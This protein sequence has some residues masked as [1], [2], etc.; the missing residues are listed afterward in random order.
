MNLVKHTFTLLALAMTVAASGSEPRPERILSGY[1]GYFLGSDRS[2]VTSLFQKMRQAEFTAVELK[3]QQTQQRRMDLAAAQAEIGDVAELAK[4]NHLWFQ[5]YVYPEPYDGQRKSD[6]PEH[7]NL[8]MLVD[9]K[10]NAHA[11]TFCIIDYRVWQET[12]RHAFAIAELSKTKPVSALK[13][14]IETISNTGLSY[15]DATWQTFCHDNP[16]FDGRVKAADRAGYLAQ[17]LAADRYREWFT[18]Q[19]D[20][21]VKQ[22]EADIHAINPKLSLGVMPA[23]HGWVSQAF[24][25]NLG[26]NQA[27]AIIDDWSMYNGEGFNA[28]VRQRQKDIKTLNP[29]N[30]YIP[31]FRINSYTTA[32]LAANAYQAGCRCDGYSNWSMVMLD[33]PPHKIPLYQLPKG[34]TAGEYYT[35][36]AL[37]NAAIRADIAEKT[38]DQAQRIAYEPVKSLVPTLN[39]KDLIIPALVPQGNGS[40]AGTQREFTVRNQTVSYIYAGTGE[41]IKVKL[42]HMAGNARPISLQYALLDKNKTVLRNE[43]IQPGGSETFEVTAPATGIYALVVSG[44]LDGQA[45]YSVCVDNPYWAFD[46]AKGIY[47]FGV[48]FQ[49]YVNA[50]VIRLDSRDR[51]AFSYTLN[52]GAPVNISGK[53]YYDIALPGGVTELNV[54]KPQPALDGFYSQDATITPKNTATPYLYSSPERMLVPAP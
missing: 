15:D 52:G 14:D 10:G 11:N 9:E 47:F 32:Q 25:R 37:A 40:Y 42:R 7:Q 6:Y 28:D 27:P 22:L 12:F 8:P 19:F 34:F 45:W 1:T 23:S 18:A 36:Y 16:E 39:Y 51:E 2:Q 48:P 24:I 20:K 5:V 54:G 26:T 21:V 53:N 35:Q 31:W 38:L 3:I 13:F 49:I 17:K 33:E 44:G 41:K 4:S 50:P 30:L 46:A 29:N 43:A